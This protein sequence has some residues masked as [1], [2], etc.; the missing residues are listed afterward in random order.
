MALPVIPP[1]TKCQGFSGNAGTTR[2]VSERN[3]PEDYVGSMPAPSS[4]SASSTES[5][6]A[7]R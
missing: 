7:F 3:G 5:L 4:E 1:R 6:E 2:A